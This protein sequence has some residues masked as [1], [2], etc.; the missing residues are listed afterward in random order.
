[1][2]NN[3]QQA[4]FVVHSSARAAAQ[5]QL[6]QNITHDPNN[7]L[8]IKDAD[9]LSPDAFA[10]QYMATNTPVVLRG[11]AAAWPACASWCTGHGAVDLDAIV[12][13]FGAPTPVPVTDAATGQCVDMSLGEYVKW[14]RGYTAGG[15]TRCLYAKDWH[16]HRALGGTQAVQASVYTTPVHFDDDWLNDKCDRDGTDDYRF[17]YMGPKVLIVGMIVGMM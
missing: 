8:Q 15:T 13:L 17:V 1:M 12:A 16:V 9:A 4:C 10:S 6:L 5:Q 11:A 2:V 3:N 7:I 14:W